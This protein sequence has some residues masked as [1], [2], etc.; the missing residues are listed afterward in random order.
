METK[1]IHLEQ[2]N[3]VVLVSVVGEFQRKPQQLLIVW[4][5]IQTTFIKT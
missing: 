3:R 4:Q 2:L 5:N 1:L